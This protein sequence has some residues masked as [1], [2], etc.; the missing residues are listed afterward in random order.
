MFT[1]LYHCPRTI[2]LHENG[3]LHQS[4]RRY[5]EHH[6]HVVCRN[7][8][9]VWGKSNFCSVTSRFR[10]RKDISVAEQRIQDAVNDKIGIGPPD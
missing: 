10:Q 5:L 8:L 2:A 3:P 9:S 6:L 7:S 4:R 1:T